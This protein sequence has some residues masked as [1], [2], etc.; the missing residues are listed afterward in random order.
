MDTVIPNLA[1][2]RV[3]DSAL[4]HIEDKKYEIEEVHKQAPFVMKKW[5]STECLK[6]DKIMDNDATTKEEELLI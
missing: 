2:T 3:T 4:S 1:Y 6:S 5:R